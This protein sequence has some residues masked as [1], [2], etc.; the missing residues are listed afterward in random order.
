M[1]LDIALERTLLMGARTHS[2]KGVS[3]EEIVHEA[4]QSGYQAGLECKPTPMRIVGHEPIEAGMSGFAWVYFAGNT[5]FGKWAK[6]SGIAS[7]HHPK[8]LHVWVGE[9]NQSMERKRA[10]AM[11]Y[12]EVLRSHGITAH[13]GWRLD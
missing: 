8:G 5:S 4:H 12:A 10:Y 13:S 7:E 9:F 11:A 6:K 3:Y 2:A 1:L